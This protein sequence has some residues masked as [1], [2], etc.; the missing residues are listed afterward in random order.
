MKLSSDFL[1]QCSDQ[2]LTS[3][4]RSGYIIDEPI[5]NYW[6]DL[7]KEHAETLRQILPRTIG[8][9]TK[10]FPECTKIIKEKLLTEIY[11]ALEIDP[12]NPEL[13]AIKRELEKYPTN[14][15]DKTKRENFEL[16]VSEAKDYP[17][18]K[19]LSKLGI[20]FKQQGNRM[21]AHSPFAIDSNPSFTIY[22]NNNTWFCFS[23]NQG[24]DTIKLVT[25]VLGLTFGG[26]INYILE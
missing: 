22:T 2:T 16:K 23:S 7:E 26:A 13:L 3:L 6:S 14:N 19:L 11:P 8:E 1:I 12:N 18:D 10:A 15:Y 25:L 17:L 5:L 20:E 9:I 24:G 4:V 21:V